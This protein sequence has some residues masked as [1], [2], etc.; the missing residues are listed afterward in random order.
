MIELAAA[1]ALLVLPGLAVGF[2]AGLRGWT[3]ASTAGMV[4]YSVIAVTGTICTVT[5]LSY[6]P[7][8]L[9]SSTIVA[10]AVLGT[11]RWLWRRR[12]RPEERAE[13]PV[14]S[15]RRDNQ[16][17]SHAQWPGWRGRAVMAATAL[18]CGLGFWVVFEASGG[19]TGVPQDWDAQFHG[20]AIR[21]IAE[22]GNADPAALAAINRYDQPEGF[23]Y[24]NTYYLMAS[25]AYRLA[26]T[27]L[28]ADYFGASSVLLTHA[29]TIALIPPLL[30][31]GLVGLLHRFGARAALAAATAVLSAAASALPYDLILR[32]PLTPYATGVA[33]VPAFLV[34]LDRTLGPASA[35]RTPGP[36]SGPGDLGPASGGQTGGRRSLTA[37]VLTGVA[38]AALMSIHPSVAFVA[39][40]FALALLTQRWLA[41][42][43]RLPGDAPLLVLAGA[44]AL[45]ASAP[46]ILGSL[47]SA[48]EIPVYTWP[49]DLPA[50]QAIGDLI[51]F[52]HLSPYPRWFLLLPLVAGVM[53]VRQLAPTWWVLA[54]SAVFGGL[55]LLSASYP[56]PFV[57]ALTRP[58]WNDRWRLVAVATLGA[59]LLAGH[60]V[61]VLAD[62]ARRRA[63]AL[64]AALPGG[65]GV[66]AA[67][68]VRW[69]PVAPALVA[70]MLAAGSNGFYA[71][72]NA[73]R[74]T[75][76]FANGPGIS[77]LEREGIQVL[78]TMVPPDARVMNQNNDGSA[79]MY[80]VAGVRPVS[81]HIEVAWI[82][83]TQDL[84][85]RR[86]NQ[87]DTDTQ[88]QAAVERLN[89]QY[90]F[91]SEGYV[92][93][94]FQR[95]EGLRNL[96][97]VDSLELVYDNPQVQIY[98]VY[99]P[100]S[101]TS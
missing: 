90:V 70:G 25:A 17:L 72:E 97:Q 57:A 26:G 9:L 12:G 3:L 45:V 63:G 78:A 49:A 59:I 68:A 33:L 40:V 23:F 30:T 88:V 7:A 100:A 24:P 42:P 91:L 14:A 62:L 82:S 69:A 10:A 85:Q 11:A 47:D 22:T 67:R 61:V 74:I 99:R 41:A 80:A 18:G 31:L 37:A 51:A 71:E 87:L 2:A 44:L 28:W 27:A 92:R 75:P 96:D 84:L 43:R 76:Q 6:S 16:E 94:W 56:Q 83:P 55:F 21:Y 79:G 50:A 77:D 19:L 58:W 39:A 101:P 46:A 66:R 35:A 15:P 29:V 32:G 34:L 98:R 93:P 54:G 8:V 4:S 20:N 73:T 1:L 5:G 86:F 36:V 81:G 64:A 52:S 60:G 13:Q 53:A 38:A 89:I 95:A 48:G 65:L